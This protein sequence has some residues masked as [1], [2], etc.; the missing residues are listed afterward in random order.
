MKN[1][2]LEFQIQQLRLDVIIHFLNSIAVFPFA[3]GLLTIWGYFS[4]IWLIRNPQTHIPSFDINMVITIMATAYTLYCWVGNFFRL[5]KI[6]K[7][8]KQL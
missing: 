6:K 5:R 7:L 3:I 1:K 8:E 4:S 2:N